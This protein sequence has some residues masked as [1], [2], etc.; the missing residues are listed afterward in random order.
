MDKNSS[1]TGEKST[2]NLANNYDDLSFPKLSS[3][4]PSIEP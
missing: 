1:M 2:Y 4:K 3:N